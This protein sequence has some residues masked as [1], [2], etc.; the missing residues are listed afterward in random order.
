MLYK[1]VTSKCF[2]LCQLTD[3]IIITSL[4]CYQIFQHLRYKMTSYINIHIVKQTLF[5][6]SNSL[7]P[8]SNGQTIEAKFVR[9]EKCC[10]QH[11]VSEMEIRET[12]NESDCGYDDSYVINVTEFLF[13]GKKFVT[14][15][16]NHEKNTSLVMRIQ[17]RNEIVNEIGRM[18]DELWNHQIK[19]DFQVK[20]SIHVQTEVVNVRTWTI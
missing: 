18:Q 9:L 2:P 1:T 5:I 16:A 20:N 17:R 8:H 10:L 7:R 14:P 11:I 4:H 12:N 15:I 13:F 3:L 6:Q 19:A